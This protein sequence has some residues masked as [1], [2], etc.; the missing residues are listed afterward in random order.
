MPRIIQ[1]QSVP[2][3]ASMYAR[4]FSTFFKKGKGN[5]PDIEVR[6]EN[7][8]IAAEEIKAYNKICGFE[9]SSVASATYLHAFIFPAQMHLLSQMEV[10]FPLP[11]LI[12]FANSI[13]QHRALHIGE[14]FSVI[15]KF[16]NLIAHDKG[17]AF[18]VLSYIEVSGKRIWEETS[19]YLFKGKEGI[20]SVLEWEQ[21][22]L[23][24]NA[25]KESWSLYPTMGFDF[26]KASGDFNPIHLHPL[27]AKLFGFPTHIIHGMW[28]VGK[29]LALLGN[30]MSESFEYTVLFKVPVFLPASIIFRH[31]K[32][33]NGFNFDVVD[34][35]QEKPHLK[36][37]INKL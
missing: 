4:I 7:N 13:K 1:L 12:H 10:P 29:I 15:T 33:D 2:N 24:E 5:L 11:G 30:R 35:T 22:V 18:E 26:A 9:T 37:Y 34:K 32:T 14:E 28:S 17:Q 21:P 23:P 6:L 31:E 3:M 25:I 16:G 8:K 27:S 19:V 36:G 20:G